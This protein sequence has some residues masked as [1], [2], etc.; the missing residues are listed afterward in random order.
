MDKKIVTQKK[1]LTNFGY[2]IV[3]QTNNQKQNN[4]EK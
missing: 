4:R 2:Q 1:L 3:S